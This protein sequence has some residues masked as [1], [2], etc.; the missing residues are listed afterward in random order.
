MR[1]RHFLSAAL[2]LSFAAVPAAAENLQAKL[3]F[4]KAVRVGEM[5]YLS[6]EL[7]AKPGTMTLVE[8]GI[9]PETK[10]TMENIKATLEANGSDMAHVVK[11]TVMMADIKEWQAMN[12]VY[13]TYFQPG[14]YPARSA[15]GTSGL[16]LGAR[17]EI[18]CLATV[19]E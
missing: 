10:Q 9:G 13:K 14:H 18:E 5:L 1:A 17:V 3:P 11:C 2:L 16:A 15:M 19:K 7:G 12:A 6:G 4:S 8:G